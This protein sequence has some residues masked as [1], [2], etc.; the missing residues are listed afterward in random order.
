MI[1][2]TIAYLT[3]NM[4]NIFFV[5]VNMNSGN[6]TDSYNTFWVGVNEEYLRI[7]A[8]LSPLRPQRRHEDV[9]ASRLNGVGD[10]ALQRNEF[11]TWHKGQDGSGDPTL[12]CSG[13]QG[14][15]KTYIR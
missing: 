5:S 10:W 12:L 15:G 14:V 3:D 2:A 8:W 9:W 6:V 7:Q 4:S 11:R 1:L 13:D